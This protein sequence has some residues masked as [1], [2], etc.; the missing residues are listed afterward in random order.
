M[1]IDR[2][3]ARIEVISNIIPIDGADRI[4]L[5]VIQGWQVVIA[6]KDNFKIG[7]KVVYFEID[8]VLPQQPLFEFM[9][10]R[11]FRV[12]TIKLRKTISQGLVMPLSIID[13]KYHS[14]EVGFDLTDIIG[15]KKFEPFIEKKA[16]Q[17]N[18]IPSRLSPFPSY[19]FPKTDQE[20]IQNCINIFD[21]YSNIDYNVVL[22]EK[23]HGES[24]SVYYNKGK[25]GV[26]SRNYELFNNNILSKALMYINKLKPINMLLTKLINSKYIDNKYKSLL[27]R[28]RSYNTNQSAFVGYSDSENLQERIRQYCKVNNVNYAF[29][30]ELVGVGHCGNYYKLDSEKWYVFDIHDIDKKKYLEF[31]A[32]KIICSDIGLYTVPLTNYARKQY[33]SDNCYLDGKLSIDKLMSNIPKKSSIA[34]VECEGVVVNIEEYSTSYKMRYNY[35]IDSFKLINPQWLLR[36]E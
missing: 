34:N 7:D 4:E 18:S 2:K 15:V 14:K 33:I 9:R 8:S 5:A 31:D 24:M 36:N 28:L 35:K 22:T 12:K 27:K 29:Q 25:F 17:N 11:K 10:D 30:G 3:L 21:K 6:K 19:L 32:I 26:C 23:L 20:R 13:N 1:N 16:S